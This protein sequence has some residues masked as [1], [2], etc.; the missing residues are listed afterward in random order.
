MQC[1]DGYHQSHRCVHMLLLTIVVWKLM[2]LLLLFPTHQFP[3]LNV[4]N[5]SNALVA[6][7]DWYN[8]GVALGIQP[9]KLDTIRINH[10]GTVNHCKFNLYDLWL[11]TDLDAS[12]S[13]LARALSEAGE[14]K[15]AATVRE[16]YLGIIHGG[17]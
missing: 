10:H 6:V 17:H 5:I 14:T 3:D 9:H 8:L 1:C 2:S 12:W 15:A 16:K 13:K 11:R 4:R 7:T